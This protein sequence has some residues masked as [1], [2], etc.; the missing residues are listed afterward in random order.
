MYFL[1]ETSVVDGG[2]NSIALKLDNYDIFGL[3]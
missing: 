1:M 3:E 2:Q